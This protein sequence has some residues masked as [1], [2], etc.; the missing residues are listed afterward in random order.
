MDG[1]SCFS[2]T[3]C[4]IASD[5]VILC[6]GLE[7]GHP[8]TSPDYE[9]FSDWCDGLSVQQTVRKRLQ[10][11]KE[12][13]AKN[14]AQ[15]GKIP[16]ISLSVRSR[17]SIAEEPSA[18]VLSKDAHQ[19]ESL[20]T[21]D[22]VDLVR[23]F[24][25]MEH[26][27]CQPV[28]VKGQILLQMPISSARWMVHRYYSFDDCVIRELLGKRLNQKT[29]KDLDDVA[30]VTHIPLKSC[31]RQFDNLRRVM[32]MLE[33]TH[34]FQCVAVAEIG[35]R[36]EL[37]PVLSAYYTAF[38]FLF[39]LRFSVSTARR[40]TLHLSSQDLALCAMAILNY[41]VGNGVRMAM[42]AD[43]MKQLQEETGSVPDPARMRSSLKPALVEGLSEVN[44]LDL[45]K[46]WI[47]SMRE[48]KHV[49]GMDPRM[50]S[51]GVSLMDEL[52][53]SVMQH[54]SMQQILTNTQTVNL[55]PRLK[56]VVKNLVS[57]GANLG[58]SKE[59]RDI[60]EDLI[61]RLFEPLRDAG[62]GC[63]DTV[64]LLQMLDDQFKVLCFTSP[65]EW[66]DASV[67]EAWSRFMGGVK[68]C[69]IFIY[70]S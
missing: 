60:L 27:L 57:T 48:I 7:L 17:G 43:E 59:Y 45:D 63:R 3:F 25:A 22:T 46:Y 70:S 5:P 62:L 12:E 13:V 35:S 50:T 1:G 53:Q 20:F 2:E 9:V 10:L 24:E 44:K 61:I 56:S 21:R 36:F 64:A 41:W 30:E 55:E 28:L 8:G 37:S 65:S 11:I 47:M 51:R 38:A 29:R 49:L 18:D 66:R 54:I 42:H 6:E 40:A 67:T 32:T 15:F 68:A 26:F 14:A 34:Q 4:V 16:G 58:Q 23:T 52:V 19:L 33:E 39:H 31:R 69:C